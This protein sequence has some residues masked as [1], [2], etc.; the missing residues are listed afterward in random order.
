MARTDR[1][2]YN[3]GAVS[4]LSGVSREKIRIWERRYGA[5]TPTRDAGNHRLYSHADVE[6]LTLI[7]NLVERGQAISSVANLTLAQL[8]DR[9]AG[10]I[11][12]A[13][14]LSAMRAASDAPATIETPG[15]A[16]VVSSAAAE[17]QGLLG[18]LGVADVHTASNPAAA[19]AWLEDHGAELVIVETPTLLAGDLSELVRLRRQ[20]PRSRMLLLY[21]FAPRTLLEP[22]RTLGVH[23]VKAPLQAD[24]LAF[25]PPASVS[26]EPPSPRERR[27]TPEQMR[28]IASLA[29]RMLCECPRHLV[30]LIRDLNAFE[31]Y[32]LGCE[33]DS[34][35][36]AALH[37]EIYEIVSRA[38]TLVE[39]ALT[40]VADEQ[41]EV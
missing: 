24:H 6:R 12:A 29:D 34:A 4:R 27:Y 39:D 40:L 37:R 38:R 5:V 16:L 36:D 31:D 19:Q 30:D 2:R 22:L 41:R 15:T 10:A 9:A 11:S 7:R 25:P 28:R 32:S 23:T 20:A 17:I 18:E 21:R 1:S 35:A 3:I 14:A 8:K 13:R 26:M 33:V